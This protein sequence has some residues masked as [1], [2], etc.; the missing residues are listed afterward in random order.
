MFSNI[1]I[2]FLLKHVLFLLSK[3]IH[4][5][6]TQLAISYFVVREFQYLQN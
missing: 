5:Y 1:N 4:T 3:R 6:T 2:L